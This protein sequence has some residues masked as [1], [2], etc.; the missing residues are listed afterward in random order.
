MPRILIICQLAPMQWFIN[1][2]NRWDMHA[3]LNNTLFVMI[4]YTDKMNKI[5]THQ[6]IAINHEIKYKKCHVK[7]LITLITE[8]S[9]SKQI[10]SI[11]LRDII[12]RFV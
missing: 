2:C 10:Y 8:L 7:M 5:T 12:R 9:E 6:A 11:F 3:T 4:L 1:T